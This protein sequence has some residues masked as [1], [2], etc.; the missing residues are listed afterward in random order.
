MPNGR[1]TVDL[2]DPEDVRKK[3]PRARAIA[4]ERQRA[5]ETWTN[6]VKTLEGLAD[7][8]TEAS[9][10][11]EPKP[12]RAR[13]PSRTS[14]S[15]S[16]AQDAVIRVVNEHGRPMRAAEVGAIIGGK[17]NT[18]SAAMWGAAKRERL[19]KVGEGLYAPMDYQPDAT[20]VMSLNGAAAAFAG[21]PTPVAPEPAEQHERDRLLPE[22]REHQE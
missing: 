18:V 20:D 3:L 17:R 16:P 8:S 19:K 7:E 12:A 13:K 2:N 14:K 1:F 10:P 15:H 11:A 21:E 4:E 5:L 9:S 6:V 22:T